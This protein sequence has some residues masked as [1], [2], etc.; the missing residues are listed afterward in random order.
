M[1]VID[2]NVLATLMSDNRSSEDFI[3]TAYFFQEIKK[4]GNY[5]GIPTPVIAEFLVIDNEIR[6]SFFELFKN[7]RSIKILPFDLKSAYECANIEAEARAA[8]NKLFPLPKESAPYQKVKVD[9]Q[10]LAIALSNNAQTLITND[11]DLKKIGE[12]NSKI[13]VKLIS[14][15]R[16]PEGMQR[17]LDLKPL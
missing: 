2:T 8:G 11:K 3:K 4:N 16:I 12:H 14:E 6:T 7:N 1:I 15:L 10:I 9:R 13:E 17:N 5:I